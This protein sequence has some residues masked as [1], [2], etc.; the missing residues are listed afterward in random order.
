MN[1]TQIL[2]E[3]ARNGRRTVIGQ[4]IARFD[5]LILSVVKKSLTPKE[6]RSAGEDLLQDIRLAVSKGLK[7]IRGESRAS[8]IAW[9]RQVAENKI[10]DWRKRRQVEPQSLEEWALGVQNP[11]TDGRTP[12]QILLSRERTEQLRAAISRVPS[13]YRR[14]LK[15]IS[16]REPSRAEVA[17]FTGKSLK[18]AARFVERAL[19]HLRVAV[20]RQGKSF[21]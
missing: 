3:G 15:Y 12:S 9:I 11:S 7:S 18:G 21:E 1:S 2:L 8:L 16:E 17:L 19:A 5:P 20:A 14:V 13:R 10:M 6:F 4:V